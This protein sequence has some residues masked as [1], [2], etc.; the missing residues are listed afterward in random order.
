MPVSRRQLTQDQ[1]TRRQDARRRLLDAASSLLEERSW[2]EIAVED[3]TAAAG[4]SRTA[5]YR[6]FGDRADVLLALL[7]ESG[8]GGDPAGAIW[9]ETDDDPI[10]AKRRAA[11]AL[12]ALFVEHGRLLRAATEAAVTEPAIA[13]V[14]A[15]FAHD[16][17]AATAERIEAD[18]AAGR[19]RVEHVDEVAGALVWMNERYLLDAFGRRPFTADPARAAAALG[20]IWVA[21][22]YG[23]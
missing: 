2:H 12:T 3:L 4:L 14:Y 11:E 20:E 7:D 22:V 1:R 15:G 16:F 5:F 17:V 21:V 6:H 23:R 10:A 13:A 8:V 9:R 19:S 18:R